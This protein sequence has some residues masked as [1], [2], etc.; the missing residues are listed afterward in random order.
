M[1]AVEGL[2][3]EYL[4]VECVRNSMVL[5]PFLPQSRP[6]ANRGGLRRLRLLI[7]YALTLSQGWLLFHDRLA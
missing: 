4:S 6:S 2:G 5:L 3:K 1:T 7:K